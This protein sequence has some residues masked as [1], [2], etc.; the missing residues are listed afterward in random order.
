MGFIVSTL[1]IIDIFLKI[2]L[3][4]Y[5]YLYLFEMHRFLAIVSVFALKVVTSN[6]ILI[7]RTSFS[8]CVF[9]TDYE[10]GILD[11]TKFDLLSIS[12]SV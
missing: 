9:K 7:L 6:N 2:S 5:I 8:M 3:F 1:Y 4:K 10:R 11:Y 12:E